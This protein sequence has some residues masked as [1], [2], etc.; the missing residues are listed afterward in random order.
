MISSFLFGLEP[1]DPLTIAAVT[2]LMVTVV[3]LAGYWP[4]RR[5]TRVDPMVALRHE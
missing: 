5:A 3:A 1:T 4:A 2:A